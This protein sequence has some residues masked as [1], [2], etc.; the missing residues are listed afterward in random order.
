MGKNNSEILN[1]MLKE[2]IKREKEKQMVEN[3]EANEQ[4]QDI[5]ADEAV[6]MDIEKNEAVNTEE[7]EKTQEQAEINK[8]ESNDK[9]ASSNKKKKGFFKKND[10]DDKVKK[11]EEEVL[12]L[13][14]KYT[15][16]LA[17]FENFR[18][19]NE[20]EKNRMYDI[21]A[22][23]VIEKLLPIVDSFD[24]G[25]AG[26]D[27]DSLED[28]FIKG[29]VQVHKQLL[30]ILSDLHVEAIPAI[31]E[32]FNPDLHNAVMQVEDDNIESNMVVEELM[33]GYKYKDSIVRYSMV[34]VAK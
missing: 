7:I 9:E 31:G 14:D 30:S 12:D 22:K 8:E 3:T 16:Q 19:R 11:L 20:A 13:K 15:R 5:N 21:G 24:R 23:D 17:E 27:E 1:S 26:I 2:A 32:E 33:K 4:N 18:K 25:M 34:K 29:M 10:N 6:N 28:S